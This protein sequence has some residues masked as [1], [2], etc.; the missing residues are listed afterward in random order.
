LVEN[1]VDVYFED[2][3]KVDASPIFFAIKCGNLKAVEYICDT[4]IKLD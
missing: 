2:P 1:K 4:G 3:V